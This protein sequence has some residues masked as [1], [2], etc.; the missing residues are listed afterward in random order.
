MGR[1]ERRKLNREFSFRLFC[2]FNLS[3]YFHTLIIPVANIIPQVAFVTD[4]GRNPEVKYK[5]RQQQVYRCG[6]RQ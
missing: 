1:D 5:H 6:W 2:I 3:A 4:Q